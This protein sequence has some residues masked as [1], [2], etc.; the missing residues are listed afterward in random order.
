MFGLPIVPPFLDGL[1]LGVNAVRDAWLVVNAPSGCFF[2]FERIA[3]NHDLNSTLFHPLALHRIAQTGIDYPDL[4]MGTE[5]RVRDVVRRVV[6][7][8]SPPMVFLTETSMV[9]VTSSD[10]AAVAEE[11][12]LTMNIPVV[13]V[14]P[15]LFHG[16][17]LDGY[18]AFLDAL[19]SVV[20][21]HHCGLDEDALAIVGYLFDRNEEDHRANVAELRRFAHALGFREAFIWLD[22]TDLQNLMRVKAAGTLLALPHGRKA[23]RTIASKTGARLIELD[24]PVGVTG[25]VQ[26]LQALGQETG[27]FALAEA[28]LA[29][30]LPALLPEVDRMREMWLRDRRAVVAAEP[31]LAAGVLDFLSEMGMEVPLL[32]AR[33]RR[34]ER[35]GLVREAVARLA[36]H[37]EVLHDPTARTLRERIRASAPLDVV[38]G[39]SQERAAA[40]LAGA[41]FVE[42]GYPSFIVHALHPRPFV[43]FSGARNL[44]TEVGNAVRAREFSLSFTGPAGAC[45]DAPPGHESPP[46]GPRHQGRGRRDSRGRTARS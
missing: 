10:L 36:G 31:A 26:W 6:E 27:R 18:E 37:T 13:Y 24:L 45:P 5:A 41:A 39:S 22:G 34:E 11:L 1:Y 8:A 16:D 7:V 46:R 30:E 2:K 28:F 19:A 15:N 4:V 42:V 35:L 32:V 17:Y 12:R 33:T 43:G 9:Q 23:A 44:L 14:R 29:R 25:T 3:L 21:D 40:W 20:E 38:I